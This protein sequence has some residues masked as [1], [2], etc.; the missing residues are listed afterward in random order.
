MSRA[1][2]PPTR[3]SADESRLSAS[4][5]VLSGDE[6][7]EF[8]TAHPPLPGHKVHSCTDVAWLL[9]LFAVAGVWGGIAARDFP[10]LFT[11]DLS[12]LT[13]TGERP[14]APRS[15]TYYCIPYDQDS[16]P[17]TSTIH[18]LPNITRM[19]ICAHRCSD[20]SMA[21]NICPRTSSPMCITRRAVTEK[22]GCTVDFSFLR[23]ITIED[24]DD[25][26]KAFCAVE[27]VDMLNV[28][29]AVGVI[30][31]AE[32]LVAGVA[33]YLYLHAFRRFARIIVIFVQYALVCGAAAGAVY[34]LPAE[35]KKGLQD[36]QP[37]HLAG[38]GLLVLAVFLWVTIR[39]MRRRFLDA[40]VDGIQATCE[41]IFDEPACFMQ[42][43]ISLL[44][45]VLFG[46][47][48]MGSLWVQFV[49]AFTPAFVGQA[50]GQFPYHFLFISMWLFNMHKHMSEYVLIWM[51]QVWYFTPYI[52]GEKQNKPTCILCR[53]Y[54]NVVRYHLGTAALGSLLRPLLGV[55]RFVIWPFAALAAD[56]AENVV[57]DCLR[58]CCCCCV[59]CYELCTIYTSPLAYMD[60]AIS[61]S[62][63]CTAARRGHCLMEEDAP[64]VAWLKRA[65]HSFFSLCG[66][67][68]MASVCAFTAFI[69][70]RYFGDSMDPQI[71]AS[72]SERNEVVTHMTL[73]GGLIGFLVGLSFAPLLNIVGVAIDYCVTLDTRRRVNVSFARG[74]YTREA[75]ST[76]DQLFRADSFDAEP[77]VAYAPALLRSRL[78]HACIK[79]GG[80]YL[81]A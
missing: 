35:L 49:R 28:P 31:P 7:E 78:G 74:E 77:P 21:R 51:S 54:Y 41:C 30:V 32:I 46:S 48:A 24:E 47:I 65:A 62:G 16:I 50:P 9:V 23:R 66:N 56:G 26:E 15:E 55:W 61:S 36:P 11:L 1:H 33:G 53:A 14:G 72:P 79:S 18:G 80:N 75:D 69:A 73:L 71:D 70:A 68:F 64:G 12:S 59:A 8:E 45:A 67:V 39:T 25:L 40:A 76:Y 10:S 34:L 22:M 38:V 19:E 37:R 6:L 44:F 63:F 5:R 52:D 58:A 57:A 13:C 17:Q 3:E 2:L 4:K 60:V 43:V 42:P 27:Q 20:K 81:P 29:H